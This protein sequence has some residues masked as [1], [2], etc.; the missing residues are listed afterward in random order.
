MEQTIKNFIEDVQQIDKTL[1]TNQIL[2]YLWFNCDNNCNNCVARGITK[3][4]YD[5]FEIVYNRI[6]KPNDESR[7]KNALE[8]LKETRG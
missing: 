4:C 1:N 2:L 8:T 3:D 6:I 5:F 7:I